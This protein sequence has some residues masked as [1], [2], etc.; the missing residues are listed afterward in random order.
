MVSAKTEG[1][2]SRATEL[3]ETQ[4]RHQLEQTN[5]HDFVTIEPDSGD[6]FFGKTLSE[7]IQASRRAYPDRLAFECASDTPPQS[8]SG[9]WTRERCCR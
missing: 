2:V 9:C 4:L 5:L 3:Y 1:V 6:Y 7:A 8:T